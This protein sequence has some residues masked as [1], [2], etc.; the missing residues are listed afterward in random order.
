MTEAP[1]KIID[2]N[3]KPVFPDLERERTMKALAS[4]EWRNCPKCGWF[5]KMTALSNCPMCRHPWRVA[6]SWDQ[7]PFESPSLS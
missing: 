7:P 3:A 2:P 4:K 1:K 6:V 5:Y